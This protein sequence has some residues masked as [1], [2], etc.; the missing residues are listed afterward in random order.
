[1]FLYT[2]IIMINRVTL[3]GKIERINTI[4]TPSGIPFCNISVSTDHC[5]YD[6]KLQIKQREKVVHSVNLFA[7]LCEIVNDN[8]SIGDFIYI[9]GSLMRKNYEKNGIQQSDYHI[10]ARDIRIIYPDKSKKYSK[11]RKFD[12]EMHFL[13]YE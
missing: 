8:A 3:L 2:D 7:R 6:K 1:M 10:V 5:Y 13:G 11:N 9:E 12:I 4:N